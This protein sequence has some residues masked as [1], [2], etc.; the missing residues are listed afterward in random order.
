[1]NNLILEKIEKLRKEINYHTH[2]YYV[3]AEP[4]ISDYE[5][6]G[7]LNKLQK[8]EEEHPEFITPNSPTQRVGSDLTK[9]TNAI[10]HKTPMLS[11]SNTYSEDELYSFDQR[12]KNGLEI[13]NEIEYVVE[14]KIDGVSASLHYDNGVLTKAATRGDGKVGEEITANIRT[15]RSIP[16]TVGDT[17]P[18]EVRGEVFMPI[19]GFEKMNSEREANGEKVFAN[20]RNSTA[21]TLKLQDPQ[22]VAK[23]PL[24][25]FT[26]YILGNNLNVKSQMEGLNY[27]KQLGFKTNPESLLCTNID[28]VIEYCHKWESQRDKLP[29]EIDGVVIKVNLLQQQQQLG[30]IAKSPRWATSFKFKA[31]QVTTKL[32]KVT[33]Q[34]GRTGAITPV[35]ELEPI[36]LAGS[37][38]S[39]ATLHNYDEIQRKDIREGDFV[40]LEKG[41]DV[42][43]K[44]VAVDLTKRPSDTEVLEIP[45]ECPVCKSQ[46]ERSEN[47]VAL[48]C[49]NK[50]C[51]AQ[52]KG[53]L[54][55]F[56]SR[57]AMD[58]EGLGEALVNQ[59]VD[60]LFLK[61]F[62]DIYNLQNHESQLKQME[63]FGEK[64]IEN[65]FTSIE[66]SKSQPFHKVLFALGIRY[67]GA[68]VARKLTVAFK[69]IEKLKNATLEELEAVDEIGPSI[70]NSLVHYFADSEN[71]KMIDELINKGLRFEE[72]ISEDNNQSLSGLSFVLTGSLQNMTRDEAKEKIISAG[73]KFVSS[74]SKKTNYLVSGDNAGSKLEKA[75]KLGVEIISEDELNNLLSK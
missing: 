45:T 11:L 58:I 69:T 72:E 17:Q 28:E 52:I 56:A 3:L 43:P 47:E 71:L 60:K 66:N 12:V 38:I 6:D 32:K 21:G 24:D 39:R 74:L 65:L 29:Y 14:L 55:H 37:T 53:K 31:K 2:K 75:K 42:I 10:T 5:F 70:S 27:L 20:P 40:K 26:Y 49:V 61:S 7:L 8:L 48:Y 25:I 59:F 36:L 67:V 16:L 62:V 41:G 63:G 57:T 68:G 30:S 4:E 33:W 15:I 35:A 18:F 51:P 9:T 23:R 13:T 73:G 50:S 22:E 44:V 64:S 1:M 46:L 54:I 34:V 19:E